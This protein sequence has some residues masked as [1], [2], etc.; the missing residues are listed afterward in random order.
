MSTQLCVIE[1]LLI[2]L[3]LLHYYYRQLPTM[4]TTMN[5]SDRAGAR[6]W[7]AETSWYVFFSLK[8]CTNDSDCLR[9]DYEKATTT[10]YHGT[11]TYHLRQRRPL[12][13][14][15]GFFCLFLLIANATARIKLQ[16]PSI[17]NKQRKTW[18]GSKQ[19][20]TSV[21]RWPGCSHAT[22][23]DNDLNSIQIHDLKWLLTVNNYMAGCRRQ[24][25]A[26]YLLFLFA[27]NESECL[28]QFNRWSTTWTSGC[29]IV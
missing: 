1:K 15:W 14:L 7:D 10:L 22:W 4:T 2:F 21:I 12:P 6:A 25:S 29:L 9:I 27:I 17:L 13:P 16:C 3:E 11:T 20:G 8:N 18:M 28:R 23:M 26:V 24:T 19:F 5:V